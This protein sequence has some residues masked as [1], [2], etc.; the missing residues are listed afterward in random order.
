M[1][2]STKI[3]QEK[4]NEMS[5]IE[6]FWGLPYDRLVDKAVKQFIYDLILQTREETI[7]EAI[8][9]IEKLRKE[10]ANQAGLRYDEEYGNCIDIL[11]KLKK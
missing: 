11:N 6:E 5:E 3:W 4:F 1:K 8:K 2:N 7:K 10:V 9:K